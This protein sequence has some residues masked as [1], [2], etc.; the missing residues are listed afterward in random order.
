MQLKAKESNRM[1]SGV[2]DANGADGAP[3]WHQ[4]NIYW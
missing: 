3:E 2:F 4:W 1:A